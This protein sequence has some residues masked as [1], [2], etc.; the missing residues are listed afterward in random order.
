MRV[1]VYRKTHFNAAHRLYNKDWD[2]ATNLRVFGKCSNPNYHGHNYDLV[3]KVTGEVDPR[4]GYVMDMKV[5]KDIIKEY[6]L[7][8][9]DH[10]NLNLDTEEFRETNPTAE[11]IAI[12]I[13]NILRE[14]IESSL[15]I[16]IRLY[17]TERNF[18]EYPAT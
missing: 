17:E 15:E 11:N 2:E 5:L 14:Q 16:T 10:K 7:D 8:R 6:V 13:Y 12:V 18:V 4:T 3:V 9:F 1:S